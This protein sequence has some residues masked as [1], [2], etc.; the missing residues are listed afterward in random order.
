MI[1]GSV[2]NLQ[3]EEMLRIISDTV[4]E[5]RSKVQGIPVTQ[6]LESEI[7]SV[8]LRALAAAVIDIVRG[9]RRP[10][11]RSVQR[12]DVVGQVGNVA[13]AHTEPLLSGA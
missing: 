3:A 6:R 11:R 9:G 12:V 13:A 7:K 1:D 5:T 2:G 10:I 4:R 8:E